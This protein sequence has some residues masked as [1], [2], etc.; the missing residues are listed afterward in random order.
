MR[1]L[2][3]RDTAALLLQRPAQMR[4]TSTRNSDQS[5]VVGRV[6]FVWGRVGQDEA[7]RR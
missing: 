7:R 5:Q 1:V 6:N 4:N 2:L 3:L